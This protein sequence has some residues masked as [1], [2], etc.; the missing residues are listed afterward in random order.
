[1]KETLL[2]QIVDRLEGYGEEPVWEV[3]RFEKND[4][5]FEMTVERVGQ[6]SEHSELADLVK[7]VSSYDDKFYMSS[8]VSEYEGIW[9]IVVFENK[10]K[11]EKKEVA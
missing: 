9:N 3:T 6:I 5:K 2:K 7:K 1:M 4:E 11:N 10:E 8:A